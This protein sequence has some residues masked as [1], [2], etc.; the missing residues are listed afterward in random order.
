MNKHIDF[1]GR[2]IVNFIFVSLVIFGSIWFIGKTMEVV[3]LA[4]Y[5]T[6]TWEDRLPYDKMKCE[7]YNNKTSEVEYYDNNIQA[8]CYYE[9]YETK[10]KFVDIMQVVYSDT[11]KFVVN[12]ISEKG[13]ITAVMWEDDDAWYITKQTGKYYEDYNLN[14][15]LCKV[16]YVIGGFNAYHAT[17]DWYTDSASIVSPYG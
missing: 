8:Y 1:I 7:W 17:A 11:Q 2:Q 9:T 14:R 12:I 4:A 13:S 6:P 5:S 10:S 15:E 16:N 3:G